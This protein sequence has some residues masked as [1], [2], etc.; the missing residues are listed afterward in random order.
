M[1]ATVGNWVWRLGL[2]VM[3]GCGS[4]AVLG[5]AQASSVAQ[6]KAIFDAQCAACH[7]VKPGVNGIGPSLYGVYGKPAAHVA[8][9]AF[10]AALTNSHLVWNKV[11]LSKFL[12]NPQAVVP[13]TKMPYLGLPSAKKRAEVIAYLK[14]P[15]AK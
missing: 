14:N 10:S 4:V 15:E 13:G 1:K 11:T 5:V 2:G 3:L 9:F 6:G 7:S 8:G 12:A